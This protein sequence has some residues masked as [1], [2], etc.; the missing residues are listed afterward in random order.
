M[1]VHLYEELG[2]ECLQKLRGMFAL[3]VW[4]QRKEKLFLARD[5]F[6]KKPLYYGMDGTRLLFGSE[7]KAI[8]ACA[9]GLAEIAPQG[10]LGFFHFG[11]IPDPDT[12]FKRIKKLPVLKAASASQNLPASIP[13]VGTVPSC[14][15]Y[16]FHNAGRVRRICSNFGKRATSQYAPREA[17]MQR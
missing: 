15:R 11:Y 4:D 12:S 9:P 17:F 7:I 2:P 8:L 16:C 10:L 3:A 1:I 5:R 14:E 13:I 6:G